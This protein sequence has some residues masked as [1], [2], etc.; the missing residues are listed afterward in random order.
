MGWGGGERGGE[1][2]GGKNI[3]FSKEVLTLTKKG[4]DYNCGVLKFS[5]QML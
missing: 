4:C 1:E 5:K 2:E 3:D